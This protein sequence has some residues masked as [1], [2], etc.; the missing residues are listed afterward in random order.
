M[1]VKPQWGTNFI[2]MVLK[3]LRC[4]AQRV[5]SRYTSH[6]GSNSRKEALKH[7]VSGNQ[8]LETWQ[9]LT[10][11]SSIFCEHL[12]MALWECS[13]R[14]LSFHLSVVSFSQKAYSAFFFSSLHDFTGHL[15]AGLKGPEGLPATN[16]K[17]RLVSAFCPHPLK[18]NTTFFQQ[19]SARL[20]S[21]SLFFHCIQPVS[22][23]LCDALTSPP[24]HQEDSKATSALPTRA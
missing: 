19:L 24:S 10:A 17:N 4:F 13:R 6:C 2:E 16:F 15:K 1:C 8:Y 12:S 18:R 21:N 9:Y 5:P 3:I 7:V 11:P 20:A 23:S 14:Q 22:S